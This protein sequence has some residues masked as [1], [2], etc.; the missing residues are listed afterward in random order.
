MNSQYGFAGQVNLSVSGLP[1]GVTASFS[2]I[3]ITSGSTLTVTA[4]STASVG[5]YTL[6]ITGTSA[7]ETVTTTI[8]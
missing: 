3:P 7:T 8:T 5:Q 1:S 6:T 4:G 2:Q